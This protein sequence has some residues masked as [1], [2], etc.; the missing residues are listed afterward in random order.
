MLTFMA[1]Y[2]SFLVVLFS[3]KLRCK[4]LIIQYQHNTLFSK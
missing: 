2:I 1:I 3:I 4:H